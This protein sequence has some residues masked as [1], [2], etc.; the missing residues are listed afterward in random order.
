MVQSNLTQH[1]HFVQRKCLRPSTTLRYC[2]CFS[3]H[4]FEVESFDIHYVLIISSFSLPPGLSTAAAVQFLRELTPLLWV[5]QIQPSITI[6][7]PRRFPRPLYPTTTRRLNKKEKTTSS[8]P[9]TRFYQ[10]SL[11]P[12]F[13]SAS[14]SSRSQYR[15]QFNSWLHPPATPMTMSPQ[16]QSHPV[17]DT[18]APHSIP[19]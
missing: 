1:H 16:F 4:L 19:G 17:Q 5:S 14:F 2:Q 7:A 13:P 15:P 3:L 12:Q 18:P 8:M 9:S 11:L 6:L 10:R